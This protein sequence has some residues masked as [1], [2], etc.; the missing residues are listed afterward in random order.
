M[1]S[2]PHKLLVKTALEEKDLHWPAS[3]LVFTA[4]SDLPFL[5]SHPCPFPSS[6]T[7]KCH[8]VHPSP[9]HCASGSLVTIIVWLWFNWPRLNTSSEL[10]KQLLLFIHILKE[11]TIFRENSLLTEL[12]PHGQHVTLPPPCIP[13]GCL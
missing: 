8:S 3:W 7:R 5:R 11:S 1:L 4:S 12:N 13:F 2:P 10:G 9:L 6:F